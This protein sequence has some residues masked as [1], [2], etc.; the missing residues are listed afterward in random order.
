[1]SVLPAYLRRPAQFPYLAR[2]PRAPTSGTQ[3]SSPPSLGRLCSVSPLLSVP[4]ARPYPV[5]IPSYS[6]PPGPIPPLRDRKFIY[7]V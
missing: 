5:A 3:V 2:D 7:S 1:M 4:R 6:H